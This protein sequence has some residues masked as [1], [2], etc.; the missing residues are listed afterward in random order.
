M[1]MG[2]KVGIK[3]M[4]YG[5]KRLCFMEWDVRVKVNNQKTV[6]DKRTKHRFETDNELLACASFT[7]FG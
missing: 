1:S 6:D 3:E 7:D 5:C 4:K 2:W